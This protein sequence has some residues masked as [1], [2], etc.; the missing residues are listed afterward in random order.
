MS[1]RS[2]LKVWYS[3]CLGVLFAVFGYSAHLAMLRSS[4]DTVDR[5]LNARLSD[6][7]DFLQRQAGRG[8]KLLVH[9]LQEQ[10]SLGLGGGLLEVWNQNGK[11]LYRSPRTAAGDLGP[12]ITS[13][14]NIA[15]NRPIE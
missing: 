8:E 11:L 13:P 12:D 9:E 1:F 15:L 10:A 3:L 14:G 7:Q 5:S 2:K 6:V 4:I